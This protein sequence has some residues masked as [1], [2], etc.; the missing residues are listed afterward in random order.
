MEDVYEQTVSQL[1]ERNII[2]PPAV[3]EYT[4]R[5][6]ARVFEADEDF[7]EEE[8]SA[9]Q[10]LLL[11]K[12]AEMSATINLDQK[13]SNGGYDEP[14]KLST[15]EAQAATLT[16]FC[17]CLGTGQCCLNNN[18]IFVTNFA[19]DVG[20]LRA[21]LDS[22]ESDALLEADESELMEY[23]LNTKFEPFEPPTNLVEWLDLRV[24][25][26]Q[27]AAEIIKHSDFVDSELELPT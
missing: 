8:V 18:L 10:S 2:T 19:G 13:I 23:M 5:V 26:W 14:L 1:E 9:L 27:T 16:S 20:M 3:E 6:A 21:Y 12:A 22:E 4:F 17:S 24:S 15:T 7:N 25:L 11:L